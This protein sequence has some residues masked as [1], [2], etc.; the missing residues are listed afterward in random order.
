MFTSHLPLAI[1]HR[2][3]VA[4][5]LNGCDRPRLSPFFP[6]AHVEDL[7]WSSLLRRRNSP[8]DECMGDLAPIENWG[9][10]GQN[11]L[12]DMRIVGNT[13]LVWDGQQ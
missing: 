2:L 3:N 8:P 12:H 1:C 4:T 7:D 10:S 6:V 5:L 11:C 13:Q 9:D